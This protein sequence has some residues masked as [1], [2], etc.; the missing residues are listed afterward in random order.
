MKLADFSGIQFFLFLGIFIWYAIS[1][2]VKAAS[3]T[4]GGISLTQ[5]PADSKMI[6]LDFF[7]PKQ[8]KTEAAAVPLTFSSPA[9]QSHIDVKSPFKEETRP[10]AS[11]I[12][13]HDGLRSGILLWQIMQPC[14]AMRRHRLRRIP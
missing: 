9:P 2:L 8:V 1:A 12:L 7:E 4:L 14:P 6:D 11:P 5:T 13:T 3:K 10:T